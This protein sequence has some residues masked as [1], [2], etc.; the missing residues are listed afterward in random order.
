[1]PEDVLE[2]MMRIDKDN[3][4]IARMI[5]DYFGTVFSALKLQMDIQKME[6]S[7]KTL[8]LRVGGI[9]FR[10]LVS[11]GNKQPGMIGDMKEQLERYHGSIDYE[12]GRI[13]A[14]LDENIEELDFARTGLESDS[15]EL[16]ALN[17]VIE[18]L[19]AFAW[20][21]KDSRADMKDL[22]AV[23]DT[24]RIYNEAVKAVQES[25]EA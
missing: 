5:R 21:F 23:P 7:M 12:H 20:A 17:K 14:E 24:L 8:E 15:P 6:D 18:K 1:M 10:A 2:T 19:G 4:R 22:F 25:K 9:E 16:I 11:F 3:E 13:L